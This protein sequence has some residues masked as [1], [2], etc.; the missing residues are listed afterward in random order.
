MSKY[1]TIGVNL[2]YKSSITKAR[3]MI[4]SLFNTE[5]TTKNFI[6]IDKCNIFKRKYNSDE[7][8]EYTTEFIKLNKPVQLIVVIDGDNK[9]LWN[10]ISELL[11]HLYKRNNKLLYEI[12]RN[13][14]SGVS[15]ARNM[16]INHAIG[17]F[18]KFCDDDDLSVNINELLNICE[19]HE[20]VDYIEC[21]M[22][23]LTKRDKSPMFTGWYPTNVIIKTNW[24]IKR[25]LY[26]VPHIVGEDSVWRFDL[27]YQ[28]HIDNVIGNV[29]VVDKS[30]YL[31]YFK[32]FKTTNDDDIKRYDYML[33]NVFN[34]EKQL[35]GKI[36]C[37]PSLFQILSSLIRGYNQEIKVS[38]WL[39]THPDDFE[40]SE[41][42]KQIKAL[43]QK[44][45]TQQQQCNI[46]N[47]EIIKTAAN[48]YYSVDLSDEEQ[49]KFNKRWA[50]LHDCLIHTDSE[51]NNIINNYMSKFNQP[52]NLRLF[53]HMSKKRNQHLWSPSGIN[54]K[55]H[56]VLENI[57][58]PIVSWLMKLEKLEY[59]QTNSISDNMNYQDVK[60]SFVPLS[61]I[62]WCWFNI[63]DTNDDD[64]TNDESINDDSTNDE[65]TNDESIN[66]DSTNDDSTNDDSTTETNEGEVF[67]V[68]NIS[69]KSHNISITEFMINS[70][71]IILIFYIVYSNEM[72]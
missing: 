3:Q 15:T 6:D 54:N 41:T 70:I 58:E 22:T 69:R 64:S 4:L 21:L 47:N 62:L 27:Y 8:N 51:L 56:K 61:I 55:Y 24:L 35:F 50:I 40:F 7:Y 63:H 17:K 30:I 31:I 10:S 37:N 60:Y 71:L 20:S 1:L 45:D 72:I 52:W 53:I 2:C 13:T 25:R 14:N 33:N 66:D 38:D 39:L 34:H 26:F 9:P 19:K 67:N 59:N 12:Y 43:H 29:A 65:S 46:I 44:I 32:S 49:I 18:I 28:L 42:I 57:N 23:V 5:T 16:I 36:P 11:Q 68:V 48:C